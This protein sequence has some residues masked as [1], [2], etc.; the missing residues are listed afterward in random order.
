MEQKTNNLNV[1]DFLY[2]NLSMQSK[3]LPNIQ[4][5]QS[6][7]GRNIFKTKNDSTKRTQTNE[8]QTVDNIV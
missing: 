5:A 2:N 8:E 4:K 3:T 1:R 6:E 7:I